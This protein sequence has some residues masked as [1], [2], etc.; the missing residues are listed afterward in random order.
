ME[1]LPPILPFQR[2]L[3]ELDAQM[4]APSFY[5]N[6]RRATEVSR[7]HQKLGQLIAEHRGMLASGADS[8]TLVREIHEAA[9]AA[10]QVARQ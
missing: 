5:A 1:S 2:R 6:A 8:E 7:E 10:Y 3:D 4:A 9:L